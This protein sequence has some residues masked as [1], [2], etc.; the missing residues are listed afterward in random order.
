MH[1]TCQSLLTLG[2][3][4]SPEIWEDFK[5][6]KKA[7]PV[8]VK[9]PSTVPLQKRKS[10]IAVY[11]GKVISSAF[12]IMLLPRSMR[13]PCIVVALALGTNAY[14]YQSEWS[15]YALYFREEHNWTSAM[16]AGICQMSGDVIGAFVLVLAA[17]LRSSKS[18]V[19][20]SECS[21]QPRRSRCPLFSKPYNIALLLGAW[22]VLNMGLTTHSL[23]LAVASQVLMGTVYVFFMQWVNEMNMLYAFGDAEA[24][25]RIRTITL[26]IYTSLTAMA[27]GSA[28]LLYENAGRLAP[29]Y[30]SAAL[31]FL[32]LL[33][34]VICFLLRV[35]CIG[36]L[37]QIEEAR[38]NVTVVPSTATVTSIEVRPADATDPTDPAAGA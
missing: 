36:N 27:S 10:F 13:L 32:V 17:K 1:L 25:M 19:V 37:E 7:K 29:F 2:I 18:S 15:T 30:V 20:Q 38:Y 35:G 3:C 5:K 9:N 33:I 11:P 26:L 23:Q 28:L 31:C 21:E 14:A 6:W 24:Y 4:T 16:W 22:V 8:E 12:P 34:Y